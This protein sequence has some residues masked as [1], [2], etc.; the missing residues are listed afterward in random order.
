MGTYTTPYLLIPESF[1]NYSRLAWTYHVN[2]V[3]TR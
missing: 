1:L 3:S 2:K